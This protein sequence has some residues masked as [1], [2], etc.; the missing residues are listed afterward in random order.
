MAQLKSLPID[1]LIGKR[2][3]IRRKELK[4]S[5]EKLSEYINISQQ[6][7]SRY[8]RGINKIN[9]SHLVNIAVCLNTPISWFFLDCE[10]EDTWIQKRQSVPVQTDELKTRLEQHWQRLTNA[11]RRSFINFLDQFNTLN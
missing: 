11:Q 5:A 10:S 9:V 7:L 2:I 6:Q 4:L 8:E 3:Q 1:Q